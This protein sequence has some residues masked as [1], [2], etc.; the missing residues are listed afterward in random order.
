MTRAVDVIS[1]IEAAAYALIALITGTAWL[2]RRTLQQGLLVCAIGLLGALSV[3][4]RVQEVTGHQSALLAHLTIPAFLASGYALALFRHS[5]IPASRIAL[6]VLFALLVAVSLGRSRWRFPP[7]DT[8]PHRRA[9]GAGM[10]DAAALERMRRRARGPLLGGLRRRADPAARPA[11]RALRRLW[12]AGGAPAR[13]RRHRRGRRTAAADRRALSARRLD[14]RGGDRPAPL[15][16]LRAA[17]VAAPAVARPRGVR[18]FRRA[19]AELLLAADTGPLAD[20]SLDWALRLVGAERGL[21]IG[22]GRQLLAGRGVD[23]TAAQEL[24][25]LDPGTGPRL[26]AVGPAAGGVAL[27]APL[28]LPGE[29]GMIVVVPGAFTPVFGGDEVTRLG[30]YAVSVAAALERAWLIE[31]RAATEQELVRRA[32]ELERSNAALE[33][34]AYIASHD[35]QEPLRMVASYLELLDRRYTGRLDADA[36]EFLGFAVEGAKRMQVLINDLLR[37]SRAGGQNAL[38][39]ADGNAVLDAALANLR[40]SLEESGARVVAEQLPVVR[41]DAPQLIQVFQNLVANAIKFRGED[42]VPEIRIGAVREGEAWVFT[43]QDNGIGIEPRHAERVFQVFKR[44]HPQTGTRERESGS[45]SAA[46]WSSATAAGSGSNPRRGV[47]RCSASPCRWRSKP[48]GAWWRSPGCDRSPDVGPRRPG[49]RLRPR[50][51]LRRPRGDHRHRDGEPGHLRPLG[52]D[53][54]RGPL[55]ERHQRHRGDAALLP[56]PLACSG[57]PVEGT[58]AGATGQARVLDVS[59]ASH[60]GDGFDRFVIHLSAPPASYRVIPQGTPDFFEDAS[61]RPVTLMGTAGVHVTLQGVAGTPVYT[62][63]SDLRPGLAQ[64]R[65][66]RQLGSF[67][68]VVNW[69]LGL[70]KN[71]CVRVIAPT[72]AAPTLVVDIATG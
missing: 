64:L 12:R 18:A 25:T 58:V 42:A 38:E 69:G 34:F 51:R 24:A 66:A 57:V 17:S 53:V 16:R 41:G 67:E 47:A 40:S 50:R 26:V 72:A 54:D 70:T 60:E 52:L 2:R 55:D 14:S 31:A 29:P 49:R 45:P 23:V 44:L 65:E 19:T 63:P 20:R 10:G 71:G 15:R 1:W 9:V 3:L 35:L 13:Q 21:I 33:E 48:P 39:A 61:G 28:P 68:G 56:A 5:V 32:D 6:G 62:G 22:P 46:G 8:A 36:D 27:V 43:V 7:V 37:Y 4:G 59:A 11:A 30:E